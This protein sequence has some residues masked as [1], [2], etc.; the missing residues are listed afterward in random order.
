MV[1]NLFSI[2]ELKKE[3]AAGTFQRLFGFVFTVLL[4]HV[5]MKLLLIFPERSTTHQK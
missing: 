5:K 4:S 1:S 3:K 2:S